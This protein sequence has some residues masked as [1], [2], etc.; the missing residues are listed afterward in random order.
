[1]AMH[2]YGTTLSADMAGG[3]SFIALAEVVDIDGPDI[4]TTESASHHLTSTNAVR[5]KLPGMLDVGQCKTTLRFTKAQHTIFM[6]NLREVI[7]WKITTPDTSTLTFS[8]FFKT[9]G[10]PKVADDDVI[11]Q[12]FTVTATTLPIFTAAV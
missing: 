3:S 12:S 7:P 5:T 1:M 8:G 10:A 2:G 4:D 6:A 11:N 9:I